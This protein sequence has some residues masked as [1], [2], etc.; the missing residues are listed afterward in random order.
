MHPMM[1]LFPI[2]PIKRPGS[3]WT[4]FQRRKKNFLES[5]HQKLDQFELPVMGEN[6]ELSEDGFRAMFSEEFFIEERLIRHLLDE[7]SRV[8][9]YPKYLESIKEEAN[10]RS[11]VSI[12]QLDEYEQRTLK[13][14]WKHSQSWRVKDRSLPTPWHSMSLLAF[15]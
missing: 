10:V 6:M 4:G 7:I 8:E 9:D 14:L 11:S 13:E 12:F 3:I 5:Y 15:Y 2:R 1:I